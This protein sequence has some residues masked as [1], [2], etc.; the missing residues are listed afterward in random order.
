M[1]EAVKQTVDPDETAALWR[2]LLSFRKTANAGSGVT[3][4]SAFEAAA[5]FP[6]PAELQAIYRQTDGLPKA[7]F[8]LDLMPF[9]EVVREWTS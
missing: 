2:A 5:G 7:I 1:S 4:F 6:F 9:A 3:D 8:G